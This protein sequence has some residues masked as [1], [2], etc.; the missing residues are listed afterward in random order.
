MMNRV[1][2]WTLAAL[3]P[4]G[5]AQAQLVTTTT[6]THY[7]DFPD[8]NPSVS[9]NVSVRDNCPP[10]EPFF[11]GGGGADSGDPL[12]LDLDGDGE[13]QFLD[14]KDGVLFDMDED[15]TRDLTS[16]VGPNDGILVLDR[17]GDG[18]I[19]DH[20]EMF[21]TQTM[22]GFDHLAKYDSNNDGVIDAKDAVWQELK[23]WRDE[24]SDGTSQAH[25]LNTLDHYGIKS[26]SLNYKETDYQV[27]DNRII[28][29]GF[30]E[31]VSGAVYKAVDAVFSFV[32][33]LA[34]DIYN[35]ITGQ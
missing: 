33:D 8:G 35:A 32:K 6:T 10:P 3:V 28:S 20:S 13:I 15:G 12:V 1:I 34:S 4:V 22:R 25:E 9:T 17:N 2:L 5:A 29:E 30:F 26:I 18:T 11:N 23:V 21:G 24:N 7:Y 14:R 31:T 16:W 27:G 19:N